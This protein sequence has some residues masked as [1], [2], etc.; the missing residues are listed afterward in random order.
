MAELTGR[1]ANYGYDSLYRLTSEGVT[2]DPHANNFSNGFTYD[3]V[4]NRRQ[5]RCPGNVARRRSG[6]RKCRR[7][8][9]RGQL[10]RSLRVDGVENAEDPD[11]SEVFTRQ[12]PEDDVPEE[13]RSGSNRDS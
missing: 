1:T 2:S 5:W 13:Y 12:V 6:F 10:I 4:G 3:A 8:C 11:V 7:T 9:G